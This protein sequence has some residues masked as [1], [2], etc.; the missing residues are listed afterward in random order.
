MLG[1]L[2]KRELVDNLTSG[3]YI[4]TS[5]LCV[6]LC[7]ASII[8]MSHNY[9]NRV[10]D[11]NLRHYLYGMSHW[12]QYDGDASD[13]SIYIV[14]KPPQ[15]LSL[16][17]IGTDAVMVRPHSPAGARYDVIAEFKH[18]YGEQHHLFDLFTT[19]SFVYA[20]GVVFSLLAIFLSF[21]VICGEK[22]THTLSL[23]LSHSIPRSQLLLAKWIGGYVSFLISISP[24]L[25]LMLIF[26]NVFAGVPL[27]TE[28]WLRLLG[29]FALSFLYLS[30]F[31][32]L[33]LLVSTLTHRSAT[34]LILVIFIW[35]IWA[36]ATPRVGV[37]TARTIRPAQPFSGFYVEKYYTA[38]HRH[39][40]EQREQLWKMD[41]AYVATIDKQI[42]MG[43][44]LARLSPT[45]SYIY[46]ST[47][48][49]LTGIA[50]YKDY[51]Q[52]FSQWNRDA[53]RSRE[54]RQP[55]VYQPLTIGK[56]LSKITFDVM[57]LVMWNL[58]L[59]MAANLAFLRYDVR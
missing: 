30:V 33:G 41:D 24:A 44:H 48:L 26:L 22:E 14:A 35:A 7:V 17:A 29:I 56:S 11:F 19:P 6:T 49:A 37:L 2:I 16:V 39:T 55:F 27:E 42:E 31:F 36:L 25:L 12:G 47:A 38:P 13:K 21:D 43:Q 18:Y 15:P 4:L 53:I 51:R 50:D 1:T 10:K 8:L 46:G 28:H 23:L 59:F 57:L 52:Q 34:A 58:L 9:D 54:S 45:A 40:E 3:R 5:I 20:V 32:T